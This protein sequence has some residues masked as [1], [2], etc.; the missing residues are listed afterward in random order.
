[1]VNGY[2]WQLDKNRKNERILKESSITGM[3]GMTG[4]TGLRMTGMRAVAMAASV[5]AEE[6]SAFS[7]S[8]DSSQLQLWQ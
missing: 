7:N 2:G 4:M 1:M 8:D 5:A 3:T 6:T